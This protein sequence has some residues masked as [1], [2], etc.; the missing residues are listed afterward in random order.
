MLINDCEL[1]KMLVYTISKG[2]NG[3]TEDTIGMRP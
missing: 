2:A 3:K 1:I